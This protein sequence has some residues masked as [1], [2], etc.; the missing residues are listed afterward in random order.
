MK[1]IVLLL[2]TASLSAQTTIAVLDFE[3]KGV[4]ANEASALSDRLRN[5]LTQTGKFTV[6]ER[7]Q[8]EEILGEQGFQQ[9]GFTSDDKLVEA[10]KL[11]G[12]EQMIA[13]SISKVGNVFTVS[14]RIIGIETA[15]VLKAV[16]YD[17]EGKL[18]DL[19]RRGGMNNVA[20]ELSGQK[21][22]IIPSIAIIPL[23]NKGAAE[24]EF[25]AYGIS[26]DL[27]SDVSGAGLIRVASLR[28]IEELID[29]PVEE[30]ARKLFVRYIST[31]TLWKIGTV[32]QLSLELYDTKESKVIWSDRWQEQ[33][34][35]LPSIKGKLAENILS[36]LNVTTRQ[37]IAQAPT[38]NPEAYQLY[39]KA[40]DLYA[41][42]KDYEQ[43]EQSM[44]LMQAAIVLD[45]QLIEAQLQLGQMY[46]DNGEYDKAGKL[47]EQSLNKSK[48]LEDKSNIAESLRKQG[49]L[50][51]K[52]RDY[53]Q[54]LEK[55]NEALSIFK[56]MNDKSSMAKAMNSIAIL[57]Y[58]TKRL[59]EA[60]EYW[61][62]AYNIAKE[63]DDKLK[64]SKYVNNLGIWYWKDYDYSKAIDYYNESLLIKEEL[65][66]TR[67]YGKTLN[68]MGQVYN[69]MG[70]FSSSLEYFNQSI[71]L[72]EKL[73][74][75]KGLQST[76]LI[77]GRACFGNGDYEEALGHFRKSLT[78]ATSFDN[79]YD[80]SE[81]YLGIG[82]TYF[83]LTNYDSAAYYLGRADS[84]FLELPVERLS[85]LSWLAITSIKD[86]KTHRAKAY[87]KEFEEIISTVDPADEEIISLNWNMYRVH[88]LLGNTKIAKKYL[89]NSYFEIKSRSKNIKVK[90]DRE[91]YLS[92]KLNQEITAAWNN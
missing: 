44:D 12:V 85:T 71:E 75:K 29:L 37:E 82:M 3:G 11:I 39:L 65:G 66:D 53:A 21:K 52:Q 31:G 19:L 27:I 18:S 90:M 5:E 33:W 20:L 13:G 47:Y 84:I 63:F 25:Y 69:D 73:N 34:E 81:R 64:I 80:M 91:K 67:N 48:Q 92:V 16:S 22:K 45:D 26:A 62:Q 46:Y 77:M 42:S 50:F 49:A 56:V 7:D 4:S 6:V 59:D 57:Y 79:F 89:E 10:G 61:L 32:F 68:N 83:N 9:A 60:L 58:K 40:K 1:K 74:D 87:V 38:I 55:F 35:S 30:I 2:L 28:Q 41:R 24:D 86:G 14:A 23:D 54:S 70:D 17:H 8:M 15:T 72:K 51:R 78:I 88:Q 76:L 43:T 36:A